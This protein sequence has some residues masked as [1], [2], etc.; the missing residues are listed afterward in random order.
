MHSLLSID[1]YITFNY[2]ELHWFF[3]C[4]FAV[5]IGR[6][7]ATGIT[8]S[9]ETFDMFYCFNALRLIRGMRG[10][11]FSSVCGERQKQKDEQALTSLLRKE[12][13]MKSPERCSYRR[14]RWLDL[15]DQYCRAAVGEAAKS[16]G[17]ETPCSRKPNKDERQHENFRKIHK[18]IAFIV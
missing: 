15:V 12:N 13:V 4:L 2:Q 10:G 16:A 18:N 9:S 6:L 11:R 1:L 5:L 17:K 14:C 7:L 3:F 8:Y